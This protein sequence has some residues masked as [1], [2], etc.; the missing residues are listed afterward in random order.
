MRERER[1]GER[2]SE[3]ERGRERKIVREREGGRERERRRKKEKERKRERERACGARELGARELDLLGVV[4]Q[5]HS[6]TGIG[7]PAG[8]RAKSGPRAPGPITVTVPESGLSRPALARLGHW[9]GTFPSGRR[10]PEGRHESGADCVLTQTRSPA[11]TGMPPRLGRSPFSSCP[12]IRAWVR[13]VRRRRQSSQHP[14][15]QT[16]PSPSPSAAAT[17]TGPGL[18]GGGSPSHVVPCQ[19]R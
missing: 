13:L 15:R 6:G 8:R 12:G 10:Q 5:W 18:K 9:L 4:S 14:G 3:R 19:S 7:R 11:R 17:G 1:E 2:E 16:G